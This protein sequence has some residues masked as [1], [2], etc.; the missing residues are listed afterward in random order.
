MSNIFTSKTLAGGYI[1]NSMTVIYKAPSNAVGY[2]RIL[3][4]KSN[5]VNIQH[6]NLY[7]NV[8]GNIYPWYSFD[9]ANGDLADIMEN[10]T[11]TFSPNDSI[12]ATTNVA[13]TNAASYLAHGVE[14]V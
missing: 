5:T 2:V 14:E 10:Q 12:L 6:I 11:I 7:Q 4:I 9:L 1:A 8:S 3:H 13:D